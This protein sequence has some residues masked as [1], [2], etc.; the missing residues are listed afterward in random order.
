MFEEV[1]TT[2]AEL[3]VEPAITSALLHLGWIAR[4]KGDHKRAEK[5]LREALR[6]TAARG[7]R[8]LLP[9]YQAVLAATLADLGKVDEAERL[10]LE[11][12]RNASPQDTSCKVIAMTALA[13]VRAAQGR[14]A[15]AEDL[16]T[17]PSSS[18]E[19]EASR[20]SKSSRSSG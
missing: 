15:E 12:R 1:R 7:D 2:A 19:R 11:A 5:L 16:F 9:D 17:R 20:C 8:G 4:L 18:P 3:G 10:A 13:A 6:M 14:D